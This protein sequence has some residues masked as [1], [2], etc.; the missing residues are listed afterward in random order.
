MP[1]KKLNKH[2]T[3][4]KFLLLFADKY[5]NAKYQIIDNF[6]EKLYY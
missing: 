5:I 1:R 2:T 6:I 4:F 3:C